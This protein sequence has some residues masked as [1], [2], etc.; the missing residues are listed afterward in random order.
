MND[1]Y[2]KTVLTIIAGALIYLCIVM[3][4]LPALSAQVNTPRPGEPSGPTD[5]VIVGWCT[6]GEAAF[7][8]AIQHQVRVT[9]TEPLPIRGT[10][11]TERSSSGVADRVVVVGWEENAV[12]ERPSRLY[13]I[14]SSSTKTGIPVRVLQ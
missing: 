13:P 4:P 2:T 12:K 10:V 5:V 1:R 14:S 8:V 3:T 11:T 7:P 6:S 9:A